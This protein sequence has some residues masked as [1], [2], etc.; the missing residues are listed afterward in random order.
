MLLVLRCPTVPVVHLE[1]PSSRSLAGLVFLMPSFPRV[2]AGIHGCGEDGPRHRY[3]GRH[4]GRGVSEVPVHRLSN[5]SDE[6]MKCQRRQID[7]DRW[8]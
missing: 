1:R 3:L 8:M 6:D 5:A 2:C 7:L 4:H